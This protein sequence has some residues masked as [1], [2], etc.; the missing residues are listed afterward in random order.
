MDKKELKALAQA[1]AKNIKTETDLNEFRQMLTKIAVETALNAELDDHLGFDKH[2]QSDSDNSRNGYTSKTL[3]TEDGQFEVDTPRDRSGSFEPQL[4]K[5]HQRRFTSMDDKIL[6]LYAQGMT[7]REIVTT[8]KEM[9]D[10]D[11]SASLIS[12]VTDAVIEQVVEWQS[13]PLDAIY[14]IVYLDCIVVKIRQDKQVI[15][16]AVYLALGVNMEGHKELLGLWLSENEGAKFWLNVL[17]ELQNRGVKD[18]L[19]ACV[20]GLKGFPDAISTAFPETQIQLCIVHMV[21]NSV[22]YVPWKDYKPVTADLKRIYQSVTEEEALQALDEF[23]ARWDER[24][25]QISRS[26]R[27]HWQNLNTLYRYPA[28]IRKVIY[29]TNAIESLNSVIRKA[30][31]KRKLFPT[32]DA[33][34]KVIYLA[35]E[36]AS[37]KWTMP[38]RNWK[39]ALNRFM[40]MFEDRL[41]D[42][43]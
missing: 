19:I 34:K 20:D 13:R 5:K 6:F 38:I 16:K 24:Y 1:A 39:P 10:A 41:A 21:R 28:D 29:T 43:I 11:V 27:S 2:A 30:T 4:V 14:P 26:W 35:I 3:Q 25:P 9:Y 17:T 8:F 37:K 40:I 36:A 22:K 15:N 7:T 12:K 31:R 42:Y 23:A 33:A 18:I 32:D